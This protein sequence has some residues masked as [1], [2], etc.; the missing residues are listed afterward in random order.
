MITYDKVKKLRIKIG[1]KELPD[2]YKYS[3]N[4]LQEIEK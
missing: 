1:S 4:I 2:K 3:K